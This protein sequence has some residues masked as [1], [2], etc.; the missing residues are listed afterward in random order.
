MKAVFLVSSNE[1]L[2]MKEIATPTPNEGQLL[3]KLAFSALNHRD[4]WIQK[5]QYAGP[6][7][8]LILG[9]DGFGTVVESGTNVDPNWVGK[10]VV[11]NPS[12]DW[13]DN[14]AAFGDNFKILGNPEPGTFSEYISVNAKYI[15][16]KPFHLSGIEA[17]ALPL[18]GVTTYRALFVR[19]GLKAGEKVLITGIGAGTALLALQYA[20]AAGA[21]VYVTSGSNEK[22]EKAKLMG[23]IDGFNYKEESWFKTAKEVTGGF[24][25]IIDS[26]SGSGFGN[27]LEVAKPGGRVIFFGGT[28]GPIGNIIPNKVYWRNLS[29]LGTTMGTLQ[30]FADM[31]AFTEKYKIKP[32]VDKVYAILANAQEAFD[33]MHQGKQFGKIVLTNS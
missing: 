24:E 33:Y 20:I 13:G 7:S 14:P 28:D 17:A 19:A 25:V 1:P 30:D 6:K 29:I 23:A 27:L 16:A 10:E 22:I 4:I 3:I 5:G 32:V 21:E 2:V 18:A 9:S 8:G 26:A 15:H 12:H 31:L 11:I